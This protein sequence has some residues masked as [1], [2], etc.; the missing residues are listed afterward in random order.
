MK[1]SRP[2][3]IAL[4]SLLQSLRLIQSKTNTRNTLPKAAVTAHTN[5]QGLSFRYSVIL[6]NPQLLK[7][8]DNT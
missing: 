3:L 6:L 7:R 1:E 2:Q 8:V 4:H 5:N